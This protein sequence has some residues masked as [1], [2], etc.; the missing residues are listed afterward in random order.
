MLIEGH[1]L[2]E[3]FPGKGGWTFAKIPLDRAASSKPFGMIRV[4]GMVDKVF[5]EGKHL[6]PMGDGNLFF[7]VA[8][9][10][11]KLIKKEAGDTVFLSLYLDKLPTNIPEDLKICL[12]DV[13]NAFEAFLKLT[14][15][16]QKHWVEFIYASKTPDI[17]ANR[18]IKLLNSLVGE[19]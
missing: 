2:L 13:P 12:K 10:I 17:Q 6:M 3:K 16:Q 9:S 15:G 5:F 18:I 19:N 14:E 11:R 7:P 8:K 1:F 4:R